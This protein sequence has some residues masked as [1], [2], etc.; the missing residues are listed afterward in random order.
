MRLKQ[1]LIEVEEKFIKPTTK[2]FGFRIDNPMGSWLEHER[3]RA[4]KGS[5]SGS[6]T[7]SFREFM[8][9]PTKMVYSLKGRLGEVRK[10]SDE[11]VQ[12]LMASIKEY[13]LH[14]PIFIN[15]E[16][17]GKAVINEGNRRTLIAHTLGWKYIPVEINYYAGGELID[18]PFHPD[19][20]VKIAKPW[21]KPKTKLPIPTRKPKKETT[22]KPK[23]STKSM[24]DIKREEEALRKQLNKIDPEIFDLLF[25]K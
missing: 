19:R 23:I 24:E 10:L 9:I 13:G 18:G 25:K 6:V 21:S 5:F 17:N 11:D 14:H 22:R 3:D 15:V 4:S 16:Y 20:I 12:E 1:Y 8:Q 7:G 2:K